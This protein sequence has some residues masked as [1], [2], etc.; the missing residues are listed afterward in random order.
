MFHKENDVMSKKEELN[1][2]MKMHLDKIKKAISLAD[3][4]ADDFSGIECDAESL[5]TIENLA[6][7]LSKLKLKLARNSSICPVCR[8]AVYMA[9]PHVSE[10]DGTKTHL[11]CWYKK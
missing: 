4:I 10:K 1:K 3:I 7:Q 11:Q 9:S 2:S 5:A 8:E 6:E